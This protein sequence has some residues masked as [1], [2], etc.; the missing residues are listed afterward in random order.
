MS[1][2]CSASFRWP[3]YVLAG[4]RTCCTAFSNSK[5]AYVSAWLLL[6]VQLLFSMLGVTITHDGQ[7]SHVISWDGPW[8]P[9]LPACPC[10]NPSD[11]AWRAHRR[12]GW[13]LHRCRASGRPRLTA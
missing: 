6:R 2:A 7:G 11:N 3:L 8:A 10:C 5:C 9:I 12:A 13:K 1:L 4:T